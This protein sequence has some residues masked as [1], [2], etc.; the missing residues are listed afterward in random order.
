MN[1][2]NQWGEP[3]QLAPQ[4]GQWGQPSP[5]TATAQDQAGS[6]SLVLRPIHGVI[7]AVAVVIIVAVVAGAVF[8]G[9][10]QAS[11]S[12]NC[13]PEAMAEIFPVPEYLDEIVH[14]EEQWLAVNI[15]YEGDEMILPWVWQGE[16]WAP[17]DRNI[18]EAGLFGEACFEAEGM[19]R[20]EAPDE[21]IEVVPTC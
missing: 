16:E 15:V 13:E 20:D 11:G 21:V 6:P 2:S 8:I 9:Q 12:A 7:A 18:Q 14:C 10:K 4:Q 3:E 17:Y 1:T 5:P 19:R